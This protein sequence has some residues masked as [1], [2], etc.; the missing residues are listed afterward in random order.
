M[1]TTD[2]S[3]FIFN[4]WL[5]CLF[6]GT[7]LTFLPPSTSYSLLPPLLG[8]FVSVFGIKSSSTW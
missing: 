5:H 2:A 6:M 1:G 3:Q 8:A 7:P 4:L